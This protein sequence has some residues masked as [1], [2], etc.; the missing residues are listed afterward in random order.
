MKGLHR[1]QGRFLVNIRLTVR[2]YKVRLSVLFDVTSQQA[3]L[4]RVWVQLNLDLAVLY[5]R[6][7]MMTVGFEI[8]ATLC[9]R[10]Y[11]EGC[12]SSCQASHPH[13]VFFGATLRL[14]IKKLKKLYH[15]VEYL[16]LVR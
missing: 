1:K 7:A 8:N 10:V 16:I 14:M 13:R 6:I 4:Q 11:I 2:L 12:P 15:T 3:P 5:H 9:L